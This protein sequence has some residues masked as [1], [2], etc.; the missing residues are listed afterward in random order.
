MMLS[1]FVATVECP[2]SILSM[3]NLMVFIIIVKVDFE[4]HIVLLIKNIPEINLFCHY[5][6][7]VMV[8]NSFGPA[9]PMPAI[10]AR[11]YMYW[12]ASTKDG[13]VT[14]KKLLIAIVLKMK[15]NNISI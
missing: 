2:E 6:V 11:I 9:R 5:Y 4:K 10:I 12:N 15:R 1:S 8:L 13:K 7:G 14:H 3:E